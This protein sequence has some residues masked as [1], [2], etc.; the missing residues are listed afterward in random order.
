MES[1]SEEE[2]QKRIKEAKEAK[3]CLD[4][5]KYCNAECCKVFTLRRKDPNLR[6]RFIFMKTSLPPN[7][8]WYYKLRGCELVRGVLKVP[9]KYCKYE[10]GVVYVHKACELLEGC[11]CLGHPD[12]KPQLCKDLTEETVGS[13]GGYL[14]P[15]CLFRYKFMGDQDGKEKR[16][17]TKKTN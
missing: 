10:E 7:R 4:W 11:M 8:I 1:L 3:S 9:S 16:T 14:T 2:E 12:K 6:K 5:H 17:K 13:F 15:N